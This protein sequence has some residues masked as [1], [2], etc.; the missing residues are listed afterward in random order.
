MK[1]SDQS[2]TRY[3]APDPAMLA[4][5]FPGYEIQGLIAS[6]GMGSVYQA[7]QRSLER[8]VAI[9]ILSQ[10]FS[11]DAAFRTIFE[12]EAKAMAK[13][14]HPNLIGVYDFGEVAGMLYIIMEYVPG[15][16]LYQRHL[17]WFGPCP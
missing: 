15:Q 16:S 6:G 3:T 7:L 1:M 12:S 14:N 5:L 17:P 4:P 9:K 10:E 11:S 8:L 13:L 2:S